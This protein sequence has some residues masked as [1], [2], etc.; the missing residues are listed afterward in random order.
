MKALRLTQPKKLELTEVTLPPLAPGWCRIQVLSVGV[1]GSDISSILGKLPFTRYPVTPGHEFSGIV[2]ETKEYAAVRPGQFVTVNPIFSCGECPECRRGNIQHCA[3]T[4]VMGVV[5]YDGA[6]AQEVLVPARM[7]TPLPDSLTA[8]QGAMVEPVTV[9]VQAVSRAGVGPGSTVA[10]FGAGNIGLLV[11]Q[12]ALAYG[13]A[14]VVVMDPVASR[15]KAAL[16]LGAEEALTPR[17]MAERQKEYESAFTQIIDGVGIPDTLALGIALGA[18][19]AALT[20][21]GVPAPGDLPV[22]VLDAFKKDMTLVT[23][24]LYP[25]P[26]DRAIALI[27]EGKLHFEPMITHRTTLEG[28]PELIEK[29]A[30]REIDSI[31]IMIKV[32]EK[33]DE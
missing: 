9:A 33:Q 7:V 2:L 18:P 5:H 22:A 16:A 4:E 30:N 17:Q 13:A 24:R 8:E 19:G 31:K 28:L 10:V 27:A 1:C 3:Q 26:L 6:Y 29:A 32:G 14:R 15:L 12:V 11:I 21:Y 23:S 25:R 20:V